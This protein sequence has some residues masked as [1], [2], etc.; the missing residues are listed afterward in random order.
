MGQSNITWEKGQYYHE[1]FGVQYIS[2]IYKLHSVWLFKNKQEMQILLEWLVLN[3]KL[4]FHSHPKNHPL[5]LQLQSHMHHCKSTNMRSSHNFGIINICLFKTGCIN[6]VNW[7]T[8]WR[9]SFTQHLFH[10]HLFKVVVCSRQSVTCDIIK[11]IRELCCYSSVSQK[12]L[13]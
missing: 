3:N 8:V 13:A 1:R 7:R 4:A 2:C 11:V 12:F 10:F 5:W 6:T 9:S